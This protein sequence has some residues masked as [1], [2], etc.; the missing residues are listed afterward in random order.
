MP[1]DGCHQWRDDAVLS[2]VF[3]GRWVAVGR[4]LFVAP[5]ELSEAGFTAIWLPPA[6]KG[7]NGAEDVGYGVYDLYDLGEFEQKGSVRTKYGTKEQ[8]LSA[9]RALQQAGLQVYADTVLNHRT[10]ADGTED[11]RAIPFPQDDRL[12]AVGPTRAIRAHTRFEFPGR[13]GQ[14]SAFTWDAQTFRCCGL[15]CPESR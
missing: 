3:T 5:T 10:G 1:R 14:Y 8:Y 9:V 15:R 12:R 6:Y 4:S 7:V 13:R 11:V 2:L